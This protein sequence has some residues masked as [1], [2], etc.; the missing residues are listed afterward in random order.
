MV[1]EQPEKLKEAR[2][3]SYGKHAAERKAES[4][5]RR[6]ADPN[7]KQRYKRSHR[8][9]VAVYDARKRGASVVESIDRLVVYERDGGVCHIC[10]RGVPVDRFH[11]DHVIPVS[12]GGDHSHANVRV[13]HPL[14]NMQK[15]ARLLG[16]EVAA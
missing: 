4:R 6:L 7:W 15:G 8:A 1:V 3:R 2:Q 14:C 11:L 10:G 12:R 9:S 13:S 16:E 5:A